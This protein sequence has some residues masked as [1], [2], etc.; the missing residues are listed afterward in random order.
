[1]AR[2]SKLVYT[3]GKMK[4]RRT[5]P[6]APA[7]DLNERDIA[8]LTDEQYATITGG[9]KPI[10]HEPKPKAADKPAEDKAAGKDA[11]ASNKPEADK[12]AA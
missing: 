7:R 1:M 6:F 8:R 10:Y 11:P 3:G 4:P 5:F 12:P 2:A 9:A